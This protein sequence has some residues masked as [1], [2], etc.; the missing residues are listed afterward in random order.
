MTEI[1]GSFLRK[2]FKVDFNK[3]VYIIDMAYV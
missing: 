1:D 3:T 2:L